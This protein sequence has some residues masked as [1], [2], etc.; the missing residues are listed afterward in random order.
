MLQNTDFTRSTR[1][2]IARAA[3]TGRVASHGQPALRRMLAARLQAQVYPHPLP[4]ARITRRVLRNERRAWRGR[5]RSLCGAAC[6]QLGPWACHNRRLRTLIKRMLSLSGANETD[7]RRHCAQTRADHRRAP[8]DV[9]RK[10]HWLLTV[11]GH[12]NLRGGIR[13]A[14]LRCVPISKIGDVTCISISVAARRFNLES[15]AS[16]TFILLGA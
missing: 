16:P 11:H 5:C 2:G 12:W 4:L 8:V 7:H 15:G 1:C 9:V 14:E 13:D 6:C 10:P 3:L